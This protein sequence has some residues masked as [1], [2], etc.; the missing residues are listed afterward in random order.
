MDPRRQILDDTLAARAKAADLL[1]SLTQ[2]QAGTDPTAKDLFKRV[3]GQSSIDNS[4]AA[5][6]RAIEAYDRMIAQLESGEQPVVSV[7]AGTTV[8]APHRTPQGSRP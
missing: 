3:T 2:A 4:I 6:R 5:T 1:K 8:P 7:S